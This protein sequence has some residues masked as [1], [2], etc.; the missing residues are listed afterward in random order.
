MILRA[1]SFL[2][3]P[4]SRH[5]SQVPPAHASVLPAVSLHCAGQRPGHCN[6]YSFKKA[7]GSSDLNFKHCDWN[8]GFG[9][10]PILWRD[11]CKQMKPSMF[12]FGFGPIQ[13]WTRKNT[14][15]WQLAFLTFCSVTFVVLGLPCNTSV[16]G[17][18][19]L[20]LNLCTEHKLFNTAVLAAKH[21]TKSS[22]SRLTHS[23]VSTRR[24]ISTRQ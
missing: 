19:D 2:G 9:I 4:L 13:Q 6:C 8:T 24:S 12:D 1:P 10:K 16:Q 20:H 3:A 5:T 11:A 23:N 7:D 14:W 22:C 21:C 15:C 18:I 17:Y